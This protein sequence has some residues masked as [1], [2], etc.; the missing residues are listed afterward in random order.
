[1]IRHLERIPATKLMEGLLDFHL[2]VFLLTCETFSLKVHI[3]VLFRNVSFSQSTARNPPNVS[4]RVACWYPF[5]DCRAFAWEHQSYQRGN[6]HDY[7]WFVFLYTIC[8]L[9]EKMILNNIIS[10]QPSI[11]SLCKALREKDEAAFHHWTKSEEWSTVQQI[12]QAQGIA[13]NHFQFILN[14]VYP[15]LQ[16]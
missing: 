11:S 9:G 8:S 3:W 4:M 5:N 1:M 7:L 10:L 15:I 6:S 14:R 2:L 13:L 12:V 16:P